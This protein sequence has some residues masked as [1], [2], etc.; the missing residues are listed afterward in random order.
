[1]THSED[2]GVTIGLLNPFNR[3][4]FASFTFPAF[5]HLVLS[6]GA[7]RGRILISAEDRG[8]PVGLAVVQGVAPKLARLRSIWVEPEKRGTGIGTLLLRE[9]ERLASDRGFDRIEAV[10]RSTL[11]DLETFE[12]LLAHA[13][14]E[15][16]KLR[17]LVIE[18][19]FE[20]IM[21]ARFMQ[22][23]PRLE[24]EYSLTPWE[25]VSSDELTDLHRSQKFSPEVWPE[26]YREPFHRETSLAIRKCGELVGWIVNHPKAPG[27]LRFTTSYLRD[28]LQGRGRMAA[29]IAASVH[30]MDGTGFDRGIWTVPVEFPKMILFAR[31]RLIPF[32]TRVT[33][34]VGAIKELSRS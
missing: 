7:S 13:D 2:T 8:E 21:Q 4:A 25:E 3:M 23:P 10:Y 16:P 33:E 31:K 11:Q 17:M 12:G 32:A 28:D 15:S 1:M 20:T 29:V 19:N 26:N 9:C 22:H 18:T 14:W 24:P 5:Q 34:T 6:P 27:L 30:R